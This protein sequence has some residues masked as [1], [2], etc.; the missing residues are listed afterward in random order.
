LMALRCAWQHPGIL[1]IRFSVFADHNLPSNPWQ[2]DGNKHW[3]NVEHLEGLICL[4]IRL[5]FLDSKTLL[6]GFKCIDCWGVVESLNTLSTLLCVNKFKSCPTFL[7][8]C[9][10]CGP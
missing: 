2:I 5:L 3:V 9:R 4:E 6:S 1:P 10:F 7:V 8:Y